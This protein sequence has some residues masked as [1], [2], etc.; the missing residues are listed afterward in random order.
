MNAAEQRQVAT[1]RSIEI[2]GA[3]SRIRKALWAGTLTFDDLDLDAPCLDRVAVI[4]LLAVAYR[5]PHPRRRAPH[6]PEPSAA[7]RE[8]AKRL[9]WVFEASPRVRVGA[10]S[11]A[12]QAELRE[13][14]KAA[15]G[16]ER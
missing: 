1:R 4:D 5:P 14:V 3:R 15:L 16:A 2:R 11:P 8:W 10:L 13:L 6:R 9:L 7:A 12:R